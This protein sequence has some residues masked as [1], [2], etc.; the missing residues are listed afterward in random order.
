MVDKLWI[1]VENFYI[2]DPPVITLV[3]SKVLGFLIIK[4]ND[5]LPGMRSAFP[6][7]PLGL[8]KIQS[9]V[10]AEHLVCLAT[11]YTV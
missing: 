8:M 4:I 6:G 11:Q 10:G 7:F 2:K 1:T 5:V 3:R 9:L